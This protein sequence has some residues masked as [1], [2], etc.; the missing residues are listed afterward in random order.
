MAN[1]EANQS[2]VHNSINANNKNHTFSF[3]KLSHKPCTLNQFTILHQNIRRISNKIDEFLNSVSPNAPHIICLTEHHSRT[4]ELS[5]VNFGHYSLGASFCIQTY[6]HGGVCIFVPK[7]TQFH[8][9]NLDQYNREKDLEICALKL[10]I[11]SNSFTIVCIYRSPT[12]NVFYFLYQLELIL[13]KIYKTS[14]EIILCG[15]FNINYLNDGS[16][17]DLLRLS[18]SLF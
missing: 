8:A 11:S 17:K 13:T 3:K 9:V 12:G 6:S 2:A 4:E 1:L 18:V 14:N 5:N 15:D 10:N 16:R 7:N